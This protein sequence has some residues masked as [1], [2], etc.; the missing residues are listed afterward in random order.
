MTDEGEK[1][2]MVKKTIVAVLLAFGLAAKADV[3]TVTDAPT[4]DGR[5]D[6]AAWS[7]ATWE[8]GFRGFSGKKSRTPAAGTE[9]AILADAENLYL[10]VRARHG[11]MEE[12]KSIGTVDIWNADG[13]EFYFIPDGGAFEFYQF[14]VTYQGST[15]ASFHSEGGNIQ[16]DP[17]GPVWDVKVAEAEDGW[18]AEARIPLSAFYMTRGSAWR[19]DWKVNVGRTYHDKGGTSFSCWADGK[20]Y[21]DLKSFRTVSGFPL[22]KPSEDVWVKSVVPTVSGVKDGKIAGTAKVVVY[23]EMSGEATVESPYTEAVKARLIRK[24][25]VEVELAARYPENGRISLPVRIVRDDG[26]VCERTYPVVV[27]Y[28]ALRLSFTTPAYRGNFYPG[29]NSDAVAGKVVS[30]VSGEVTVVLEGPGFGRREARL[31]EGGGTFSFDTKG[32]EVGEATLTVKAGDE[33][34]TR[35][36][37]KLAPLGEGRHV[38][39]IENGNLVVDGK[40]V[41]RRN[42]YAE[43]YMGGDAFK[44]KYDADDLHQTK[45]VRQIAT[46]EPERLVKGAEIREATKDVKPSAEILAK[47]D[48]RI[49]AGLASGKGVY[50]YICDEPECRNVSAV[51]LKHLYDYICEKDP[52]H[53]VLTCSRA[54]EKYIDCADWFETH[55]YVNA[56]YDAEGR[57]IYGRAFNE[58]GDFISA[59]HP[60]NHPDKCVGGTGTCFSYGGWNGDHPTFREYLANAWCE[61]LRGA[62][63]LFPYAYHDLGDRAQMY[64]GTRYIFSSAEALED[65]LLLGERRTLVRTA[66]YEAALWT[67]PDGERMFCVQ[68]FTTSPLKADVPGLS[69]SFLEFRGER[70]FEIPPSTSTFDLHLL[71]LESLVATTKRRDAGLKTFAAVQ[72]EIDA[73]EKVRLGR[74]NQLLFRTV[75]SLGGCPSVEITTSTRSTGRLKMFDG[76]RDV[77]AWYDQWSKEKFYEMSFPKTVPEFSEMTVYGNGIGN[78]RVKV[79]S[80]GEWTELEP[81]SVEKGDF[82]VRLVFGRKQSAVKIRLEF[83]EMRRVELYEIELPG[84]GRAPAKRDAG[85]PLVRAKPT[86]YWSRTF[87]AGSATNVVWWMRREP[88]QKYLT[89]E[90]RKPS[91]VQEKKYTAWCL[92]WMKSYLAGQVSSPITGLYTLRLPDYDGEARTRE[93]IFRTYNLALDIGEVVCSREPPENRVE[94]VEAKGVWAVRVTLEKPCED[95][96]CKILQDRGY[97]PEAFSADGKTAFEL[98]AV[99]PERTVWAATLPIPAS[100]QVRNKKGELPLPFVKVT[101]LGGAI[102][103][104]LL[105]W[106]HRSKTQEGNTAE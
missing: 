3:L 89:F 12:L 66:E 56:H 14:L 26:T 11:R 1:L 91:R 4:L 84:K 100:G 48:E 15:F 96:T 82:S 69:G 47:V 29:Q 81:V 34:L 49:A 20:G 79:R 101:V 53:V 105:T 18:T 58:M 41:L 33:T 60:E 22:R 68:N 21:K 9:F 70:K 55:P 51:Y 5:L 97:G 83:P 67:M 10:G 6:E 77:I 103:R 28:Q 42:M 44:A 61:F 78:V 52:Y 65:I 71:P 90:F 16:P 94:F 73:A 40:P 93:F 75:E 8:G 76:T 35:K 32:F 87:P 45:E 62:K 50:Y 36:V 95:M 57:R 46:L 54:G 92:H 85:K 25:D 24:G 23:S 86:D 17:Y 74:D 2:N 19:K 30:A 88:G 39:W 13:V 98:K 59:F 27:D 37:R 72:A 31:G 7:S 63:T 106:I 64:E 38:S 80:G 104:P 102:D 99:N 43:Y